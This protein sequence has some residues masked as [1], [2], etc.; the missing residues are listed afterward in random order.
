MTTLTPRFNHR[1]SCAAALASLCL[2]LA[3]CSGSA[4]DASTGNGEAGQ[5]RTTGN[6][7]DPGDASDAGRAANAGSAGRANGGGAVGDGESAGQG[8]AANGSGGAV[9][10]GS[11][12]ASDPVC[13]ALNGLG[14]DTTKTP[15]VGPTGDALPASFN[16]F[17]GKVTALY[18]KE[19]LYLGGLKLAG[20]TKTSAI[21]ERHAD[22]P[23]DPANNVMFQAADDW[24][25]AALH[26]AVA[27]DFD[28]NGRQEIAGVYVKDGSIW[29][30][31]IG[32]EK[33]KFATEE[34]L[35]GAY[36]VSALSAVA[37]DFDGDGKDE[38]AIAIAQTT[39]TKLLFADDA[40]TLFKID[41]TLTKSIAR[42]TAG[43]TLS[44]RLAA[45]NL[46]YDEAKE[47]VLVT[48]EAVG[49]YENGQGSAHY[50]VYDDQ[51]TKFA[52]QKDGNV[53]GK[54]GSLFSALVAA[55]AV[56]DV[57]ADGVGEVLLAGLT[58]KDF[59]G[60]VEMI[61]VALDD[62]A[63]HFAPLAAKHTS[64]YRDL[65]EQA[66]VPRYE[67]VV[68]NGLDLDGDLAQDIQ[69]N[70]TVFSNFAK[71]AAPFSKLYEID[72]EEF[73]GKSS[74]EFRADNATI[75]VGDINGDK[76]DDIIA[77]SY[78]RERVMVWGYRSLSADKKPV[79]GQIDS[80][81]V[82][83]TDVGWKGTPM[84][85]PVNVDDDTSLLSFTEAKSDF[86]FTEPVVIAAIAAPPCQNGVGQL[87]DACQTSF[88]SAQ[89]QQISKENSVTVSASVSAG[90]S[91]EDRTFT[92]S[93]IDIEAT[94]TLAATATRGTSYSLE[95]SVTFTTGSMED[96]VVF[97]TIPYDRYT[98][99]I[100]SDPHPE[101]VGQTTTISVPREPIT[102]MVERSFYNEHVVAGA[103]KIDDAVFQHTIGDRKTYPTPSNRDQLLSLYKGISSNEVT[104]GQ[105][106][107]QIGVGL[108]VSSEISSGQELEL[109]Y[110]MSV[111]LTA[112]GVMGGFTVG[113][114]AA[115]NL[116]V[117]S[118][119]ST[120]YSGSVGA[121]DAA[122]FAQ[123]QYNFGLFT[124]PYKT[125]SGVEFEVLNYWV[126]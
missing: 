13:A 26:S 10:A 49:P 2:G 34:V 17:G 95:K 122:H 16:P 19:E 24:T 105:G 109:G 1:F 3:A 58:S 88:G 66:S 82:V 120:S 8:G 108:N 83:K 55:P 52:A 40:G 47:L 113:A 62:A 84:L 36:E 18:P 7:N 79:F 89:T 63:H 31:L 93:A 70:Q 39:G 80:L 11:A 6:T 96:A 30:H 51:S 44:F 67:N 117:V 25:Q 103:A 46:D 126:K 77:L 5:P 90:V 29:L 111:K 68:I 23:G 92:Q 78:D 4:N 102:L 42:D 20:T 99:T 75:A 27:G 106:T 21:V 73:Q 71:S 69:V 98:Y 101:L 14:V 119:K 87:L 9:G 15:R 110:E 118:G 97:T 116:T 86:V 100:I 50:F 37:G 115:S 53:Q 91:F 123:N 81:A 32:D 28:G 72:G 12:C 60:P 48:N 65:T 41:G 125:S 112:G 22:E 124:Y 35:L 59:Y 61:L 54:D 57:D 85:V 45:G 121:I 38:L 56:I 33:S 114:S 43:S 64:D 74:F 104:V 94:A 76:H 107:G